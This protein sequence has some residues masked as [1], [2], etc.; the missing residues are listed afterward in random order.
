MNEPITS[1]MIAKWAAGAIF[2]IFGGIVHALIQLSKGKVKTFKD[3]LILAVISGFCGVMWTLAALQFYGDNIYVIGFAGGI[4]SFMSL[5]GM[6]VMTN[7]LKS[8]FLTK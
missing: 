5:E 7:Y 3:F 2:S 1:V 4:G 8:K 6:A